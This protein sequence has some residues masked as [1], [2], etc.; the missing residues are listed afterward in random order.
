MQERMRMSRK[1]ARKKAKESFKGL[2]RA[3]RKML[4]R[5]PINIYQKPVD[6]SSLTS[7]EESRYIKSP[8]EV[9]LIRN[10]IGS[11]FVFSGLS[12]SDMEPLV[13]AFE[14][15]NFKN[16][17]TII[18]QGEPGDFFYV[19]NEGKVDFIVNGRRVG[20]ADRGKSFGELALLYTCPRAA[21]VE[22]SS[23]TTLFRVGQ[24]TFRRILQARS[25]ASLSDK[26]EL[27]E[28][29]DLCQGISKG[30]LYRL[31]AVMTPYLFKAGQTLVRKGGSGKVFFIIKEG[32]VCCKDISV[33][34][35]TYVDQELGPGDYFGERALLT[36]EPRAA[37]VI[38]LTSGMA[39]TIDKKTFKSVFGSM[40]KLVMRAQDSR[41]LLGLPLLQS[42]NLDNQQVTV[43]ASLIKDISFQKGNYINKKGKPALATMYF[44]REGEVKVGNQKFRAGEYFGE[45]IL[46][47]AIKS[48]EDI[49]M[50]PVDVFCTESCIL[51]A[52]SIQQLKD[53]FGLECL[54]KDVQT[55]TDF[56]SGQLGSSDF[57][58]PTFTLSDLKR[59]SILGEGS[60]GQV[61]LVSAENDSSE[62]A[63]AL[64][65][66]SKKHLVEEGQATATIQER[67]ILR[68]LKHPFI[69]KLVS[70]F[71]NESFVFFLMDFAR[72][73]ELFSLMHDDQNNDHLSE[74]YVS[75]YA[76]CIQDALSYMVCPRW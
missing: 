7:H 27:L 20:S 34:A 44:V 11:N 52:L 35:S 45:R 32:K 66:M 72:G 18:R 31:S 15:C 5:Q 41:R 57:L 37:N 12:E 30:D 1:D 9:Q 33:G 19:I 50:S 17:E 51:G 14:K 62:K 13:S 60:F 69:I 73:G 64:K 56:E 76:L 48:E 55:F 43:M 49:G 38:A 59:I 3:A 36:R 47:S 58:Q 25:Q 71:Q 70:S 65:I 68:R 53:A 24:D 21:S 61:W 54:K 67:N 8:A 26:M 75:F 46:E 74:Q 4:L 63:Y 39:F 22:A 23:D 2:G 29:L 28:G 10:S 40:A 42:A 6:T 16:K